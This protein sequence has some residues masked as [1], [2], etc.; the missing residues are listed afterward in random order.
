M[1]LTSKDDHK[2]CYVEIFEQLVKERFYE[3]K[4]PKKQTQMI[5]HVFKKVILLESNFNGTEF[6]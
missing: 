6:F 4:Q 5:W 3:R 1:A 2:D